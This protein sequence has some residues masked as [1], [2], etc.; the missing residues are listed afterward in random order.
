[1]LKTANNAVLESIMKYESFHF[2]IASSHYRFYS[3]MNFILLIFCIDSKNNSIV[4]LPDQGRL[5]W[6]PVRF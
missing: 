3:A 5:L 2:P 1:M 4:H 6:K